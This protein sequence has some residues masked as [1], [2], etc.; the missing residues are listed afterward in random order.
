MIP[1]PCRSRSQTRWSTGPPLRR[2]ARR[3]RPW[4]PGK[5]HLDEAPGARGL[6]RASPAGA[7]KQSRALERLQIRFSRPGRFLLALLVDCFAQNLDPAFI[8]EQPDALVL[9]PQ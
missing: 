3:V 1:S 5:S 4:H 2:Y 8:V 9:D 6:P 7:S